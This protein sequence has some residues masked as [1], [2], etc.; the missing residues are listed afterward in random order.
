MSGSNPAPPPRPPPADGMWDLHVMS[1]YRI[2]GVTMR[3]VGKSNGEPTEKYLYDKLSREKQF[4]DQGLR[5]RYA[6]PEFLGTAG[7]ALARTS[8]AR[9]ACIQYLFAFN[10]EEEKRIERQFLPVFLREALSSRYLRAFSLSVPLKGIIEPSELAGIFETCRLSALTVST[11]PY[12]EFWARMIDVLKVHPTLKTVHGMFY[13]TGWV[14]ENSVRNV[15]HPARFR[16][17]ADIHRCPPASQE[18]LFI[19][20]FDNI[21]EKIK[22]AE[23]GRS[24]ADY[25]YRIAFHGLSRDMFA[26]LLS[27]VFCGLHTDVL[28]RRVEFIGA[29][30]DSQ[31]RDGLPGHALIVVRESRFHGGRLPDFSVCKRLKHLRIIACDLRF[32]Q[33]DKD[34]K[35]KKTVAKRQKK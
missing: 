11:Y 28:M 10:N 32:D 8:F 14:V 6:N 13:A 12:P 3:W 15:N 34:K 22:Q 31:E 30:L 35:T 23:K 29:R 24:S 27:I 4:V 1:K 18:P 21:E 16:E 20:P 9:S 7:R 33:D 2:D 26:F 17:I 19:T 5:I 25:I